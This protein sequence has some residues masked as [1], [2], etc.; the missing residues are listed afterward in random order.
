[1]VFVLALMTML[2]AMLVTSV[3]YSF[4]ELHLEK[5]GILTSFG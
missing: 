2:L 1:M 3:E 4:I 5:K